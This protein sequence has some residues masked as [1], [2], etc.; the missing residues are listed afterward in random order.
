MLTSSRS[1]HELASANCAAWIHISLYVWNKTSTRFKLIKILLGLSNLT[2]RKT[3]TGSRVE[4]CRRG[5]GGVRNRNG[6][7]FIISFSLSF[8]IIKALGLAATVLVDGGIAP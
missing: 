2:V 3:A 7:P 8:Y 6:L 1:T 4:W 5:R